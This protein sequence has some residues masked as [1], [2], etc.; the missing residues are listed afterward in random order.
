MWDQRV[1]DTTIQ[2]ASEEA[3]V[4]EVG[5]EDVRGQDQDLLH[6]EETP[7]VMVTIRTETSV[8]AEISSGRDH[9]AHLEGG[10]LT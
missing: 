1:L 4:Q 10:G 5:M 3:V 7:I 8:G 2:G 6:P 9:T